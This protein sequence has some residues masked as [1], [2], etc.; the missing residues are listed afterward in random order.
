MQG[1]SDENYLA[2]ERMNHAKTKVRKDTLPSR[3][4]LAQS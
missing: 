1:T 3:Y 4:L 2:D